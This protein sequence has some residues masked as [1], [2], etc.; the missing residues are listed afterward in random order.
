MENAVLQ[1]IKELIRREGLSQKSFCEKAK[2]S[3]NT[4]KSMFNK[5]TSPSVDVLVKIS[6][7]FTNYSLDWIIKGEDY[8]YD[9]EMDPVRVSDWADVKYKEMTSAFK[10]LE[11]DNASLRE[12]ILDL[13]RENRSINN[14]LRAFRDRDTA[15]G[16]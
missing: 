2:I 11:A 4:I 9:R 16:A 10:K 6:D 14:E 5:G 12:E 15:A 3:E 13:L 8:S 1:R 7:A